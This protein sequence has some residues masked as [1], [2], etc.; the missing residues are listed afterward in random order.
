VLLGGRLGDRFGRYRVMV[1]A[2]VLLTLAQALLLTVVDPLS[3]ALVGVMQGV[4]AFINPLPTTVMGDALPPHLRA[5]GIAVYRT[6]CDVAILSAPASMG[7]ALQLAG[8]P[9]AEVV[10]LSVSLAVV[11]A[12]TALYWRRPM[13]A[14]QHSA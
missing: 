2:L 7:L 13:E 12:V 10:N 14:R 3:Y 6:V 1:P 4:A 8:F 9:A 11:I 5:R